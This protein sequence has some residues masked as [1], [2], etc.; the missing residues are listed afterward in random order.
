MR[1]FCGRQRP[2]TLG[3][4]WRR[5]RAPMTTESHGGGDSTTQRYSSVDCRWLCPDVGHAVVGLHG[6][7][8]SG[9]AARYLSHA[10][11][12]GA[13]GIPASENLIA[14]EVQ[15]KGVPPILEGGC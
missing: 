8:F 4:R 11:P 9:T 15:K 7:S 14:G 10:A 13:P 1:T 3:C 12:G 6:P 2:R 5:L